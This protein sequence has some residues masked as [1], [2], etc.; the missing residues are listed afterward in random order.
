MIG[1]LLGLLPALVVQLH[2]RQR[3]IPQHRHMGIE[4]KLLKDHGGGAA[5]QL[6]SVLRRQLLAVDV[7]M[8]AGGGFQKVHAPHGGGLPGAG[9]PDDGQLFPLPDLQVHVLQNVQVAEIFVNV[10][11]F[12]HSPHPLIEEIQ[13]LHRVIRQ[14]SGSLCA[15]SFAPKTEESCMD[16][17]LGTAERVQRIR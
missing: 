12:N 15:G 14:V 7:H 9:G 13:G 5:H 4:V 16:S 3:Q 2:R 1:Q 6:G 10:F 17:V 8:P 11:Q